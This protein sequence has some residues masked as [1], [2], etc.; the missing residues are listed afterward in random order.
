MTGTPEEELKKEL[1]SLKAAGI[2]QY[3]EAVQSQLDEYMKSV[4]E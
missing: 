3:K 1:S 4:A 2:D